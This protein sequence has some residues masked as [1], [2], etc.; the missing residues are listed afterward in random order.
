MAGRQPT[1]VI[2]SISE[3]RDIASQVDPGTQLLLEVDSEMPFEDVRQIWEAITKEEGPFE[4]FNLEMI[5]GKQDA[6][7]FVQEKIRTRWS[8]LQLQHVGSARPAQYTFMLG[9][10]A[11]QYLNLDQIGTVNANENREEM[12]RD[13]F[14]MPVRVEPSQHPYWDIPQ[15]WERA[16]KDRRSRIQFNVSYLKIKIDALKALCKQLTKG[17]NGLKGQLKGRMFV[18]CANEGFTDFRDLPMMASDPMDLD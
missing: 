8:L 13:S 11:R 9:M 15:V 18:G 2:H 12:L 6:A 1:H 16:R 7:D 3:L 4:L 5:C 14:D 10:P 17:I